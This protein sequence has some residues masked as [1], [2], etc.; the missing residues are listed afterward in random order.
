VN[1]KS[2]SLAGK[3]L[4]LTQPDISIQIHHFEEYFGVPLIERIRKN[5]EPTDAGKVLFSYATRIFELSLEAEGVIADYR[6]LSQGMLKI[7]TTGT[8]AKCYLPEILRHFKI[9]YP[10]IKIILKAGNSQEAVDSV[11]NFEADIAIPGRIHYGNKLLFTPFITDKLVLVASPKDDLSKRKKID[12]EEL[13]GKPIIIRELGSGL[14]KFTLEIFEKEGISPNVIMELTH[15]DAI[16]KLVEHRIGLSFM[17]YT[18]VRDELK[19]GILKEVDL[20]KKDSTMQF[21]IVYHKSRKTSQLIKAF[22]N[23][24]LKGIPELKKISPT[25]IATGPTN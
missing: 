21:D 1:K 13:A 23:T 8:I 19:E 9:G 17:T 10:N 15:C 4:Y 2:F 5:I 16:K 7:H 12:L 24:A 6:T 25:I 3:D 14:R 20:S 11:A 22:I 18:M